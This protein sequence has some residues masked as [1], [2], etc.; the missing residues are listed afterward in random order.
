ML[1]LAEYAGPNSE[2]FCYVQGNRFMGLALHSHAVKLNLRII[3]PDR[4]GFGQSTSQPDRTVLQYPGDVAELC[5]HLR[6]DKCA[7]PLLHEAPP[8]RCPP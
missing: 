8:L 2:V 7:A 4:P 1:P 5:D 6:I 3:T